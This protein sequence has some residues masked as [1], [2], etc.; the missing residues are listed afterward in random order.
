MEEEIKLKD[1]IRIFEKEGIENFIVIRK[2][3]FD[4]LTKEHKEVQ[5]DLT[6]VYLSGAFDERDKWKSKIKKKIEEIDQLI[7]YEKQYGNVANREKLEFKKEIY[8]ELMED[9]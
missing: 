6:S 5:D 8:M 3:T 4:R 7:E 2:S 9:K 1:L